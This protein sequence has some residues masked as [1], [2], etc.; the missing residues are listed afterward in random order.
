MDLAAAI[1][2]AAPGDEI[3]LPDGIYKGGP[4]YIPQ[5]ISG[6]SGK[7]IVLKAEHPGKVIL[8]GASFTLKLPVLTLRGNYW[9]IEGIVFRNSPSCGLFVF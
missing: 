8:D 5:E 2:R 4:Y 6:R 1:R 9:V 3:I 7:P